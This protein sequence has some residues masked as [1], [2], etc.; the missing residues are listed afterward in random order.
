MD[1][2]RNWLKTTRYYAALARRH[3]F[4]TGNAEL[5]NHYYIKA[6]ASLLM[7][8]IERDQAAERVIR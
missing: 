1:E 5:A 7:L 8:Q 2:I 3:R 4:M 6:A